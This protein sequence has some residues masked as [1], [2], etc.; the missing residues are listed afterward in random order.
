LF[1]KLSILENFAKT[2]GGDAFFVNSVQKIE[3]AYSLVTEEARNQYVLAYLSNN[4]V[5]GQGPVFRDIEVKLRRSGLETR[6]RKGY[7]QYP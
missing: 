5:I 6:H 3:S 1:G 2:T 4:E 7:Y